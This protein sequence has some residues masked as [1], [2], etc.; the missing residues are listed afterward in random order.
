MARCRIRRSRRAEAL[1]L[2][3]QVQVLDLYEGLLRA[4]RPKWNARMC[5]PTQSVHCFKEKSM[6][7]HGPTM[8]ARLAITALERRAVGA[9]HRAVPR[10]SLEP[11]PTVG[12]VGLTV[13]IGCRPF[14][15]LERMWRGGPATWFATPGAP[16]RADSRPAGLVLTASWSSSNYDRVNDLRPPASWRCGQIVIEVNVVG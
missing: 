3:R 15:D 2:A 10:C 11:S 1:A 5:G 7:L 14:F 8:P 9:L 16:L 6:S 4:E 13:L 12:S